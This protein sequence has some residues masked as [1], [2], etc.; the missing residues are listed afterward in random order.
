M[1]IEAFRGALV[2]AKGGGL[3]LPALAIGDGT[4]GDVPG[5]SLGKLKL[6]ARFLGT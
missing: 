3:G 5:V 4:T 1:R 6:L 2:A